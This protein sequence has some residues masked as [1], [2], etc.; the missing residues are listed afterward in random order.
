MVP[1]E[2]R[3]IFEFINFLDENKPTFIK[4]YLPICETLKQL[5]I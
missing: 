3:K 4:N 2:I 1:V 5:N